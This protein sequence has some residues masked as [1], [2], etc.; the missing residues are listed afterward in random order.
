MSLFIKGL[1]LP[2]VCINRV[3][4][5]KIIFPFFSKFSFEIFRDGIIIKFVDILEIKKFELLLNQSNFC[6]NIQS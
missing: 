6:F 4:I 1:I 2:S 3:S 5:W